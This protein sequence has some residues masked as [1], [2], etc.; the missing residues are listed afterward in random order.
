MDVDENTRLQFQSQLEIE[1][2]KELMYANIPMSQV[3]NL[4]I[5][6]EHAKFKTAMIIIKTIL[7]DKQQTVD[8][9]HIL[10]TY[11]ILTSLSN[12]EVVPF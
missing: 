5:A 11:E 7:N 12:C 8:A 3:R 10:T 4:I 2:I 6:E 1:P 9:K